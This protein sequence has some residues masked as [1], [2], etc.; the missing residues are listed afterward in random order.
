MSVQNLITFAQYL[1]QAAYILEQRLPLEQA[2]AQL[3]EDFYRLLQVSRYRD[4]E[5]LALNLLDSLA[6]VSPVELARKSALTHAWLAIS[7]AASI[8]KGNARKARLKQA[9][10][11][12]AIAAHYAALYRALLE[13]NNS[14]AQAQE[15]ALRA[16][17]AE[18]ARQQKVL[19]ELLQPAINEVMQ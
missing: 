14:S 8:E 17:D 9:S 11:A 7:I 19:L 3:Q 1:A 16:V 12:A 5:T 13:P 4:A 10:K 2:E 18:M 6:K 15:L